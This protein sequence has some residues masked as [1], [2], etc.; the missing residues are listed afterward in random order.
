MATSVPERAERVKSG[1]RT[2]WSEGPRVARFIEAFCVFTNARWQRQPFVLLPWQRRLI[3]E[4]FEVV[5]VEEMRMWLRKY[6]RALIGLPRKAGKTELLA[7]ILAY[8]AWFD[9]EPSA[10]GY[11]AASSEDQADRCFDALRRMCDLGPLGQLINVP[12]GQRTS[13]PKLVAKSDPYSYVQ[14]LTSSG[15]QKHG[16]NPHVVGLDE[17]HAW[18][19]GEATELWDALS[20]G[21]GARLQPMQLAITTAGTDL[22]NSRCGDLYRLGRRIETGEAEENGFFFRWWQAPDGCDYRDPEMWRIASPSYGH[23]V[24]EGFYR[25]ELDAVP[26]AT[27][28]RL[29]LNQWV[30]DLTTAWLPPGV[31]DECYT[32]ELLIVPNYPTYIGVDLSKQHDPTAVVWGQ[33]HEGRLHV[34]AKVWEAPLLANGKPD[35]SWEV[36]MMEV[37]DFIRQLARDYQLQG[38]VVYDPF[39]SRLMQQELA[40]EDIPGIDMWQSGSRVYGATSALYELIITGRLKHDGDPTLARHVAN[41]V[42]K[43]GNASEEGYRLAHPPNGRPMDAAAALVYVTYAA[44]ESLDQGPSVYE[45]RGLMTL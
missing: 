43:R 7:A 39:E 3:Y 32:D 9:G 2:Y 20:T 24:T 38:E 14:R 15:K 6:R 11:V 22:D 12:V 31:W 25:Q 30:E 44:M 42:T 36:P 18:G 16:L 28:R 41:A 21:S 35:P 8:L 1:G 37:K 34:R 27:F 4:L 23:T 17:L 10:E 19:A 5:Y 29:Y 45:Q 13:Q 33:M 26:E 40:A